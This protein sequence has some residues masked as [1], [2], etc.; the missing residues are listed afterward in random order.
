MKRLLIGIVLIFALFSADYPA[1][2]VQSCGPPKP[3]KPQRRT[4]GE[5]FPPLPLPATPLRRT[6][7][8]RQPR[9]PT[10]FAKVAYGPEFAFVDGKKVYWPDWKTDPGD[11]ETLMRWVNSKLNIHYGSIETSFKKFSY[12]VNEVPVLYLTGHTAPTIGEATAGKLRAFLQ[13]GGFLVADACC[14][15][16]DYREGFEKMMRQVFPDRPL[17]TLPLEHPLFHCFHDCTQVDYLHLEGDRPSYPDTPIVKGIDIGCRTA[18]FYF[19][20]DVSCGWAGHTHP[21]GERYTIKDAR[22]LGANLVT[23]IIANYQLG[24]YLSSAKV[25]YQAGEK[26]RDEFVFGQILHGGDWDPSPSGIA[27]LLEFVDQQSSIS[28]Q[29]KKVAVRPDSP[30]VFNFPFLYIIGHYDFHFNDAAVANLRRF[31]DNGGILFGEACCGRKEFDAAFRR[32]IARVLPGTT[33][34][35]LP[36]S[37]PV[38]NSFW[39]IRT[40]G[41]SRYALETLGNVNRPL[42]EGIKI[43][44]NLAVIYSPLAVANGWERFDHPYSRGYDAASALKLGMNVLVYAMSH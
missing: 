9:P 32:E 21:A 17:R 19:P 25:Y 10:L 34:K 15:S 38:Y 27:N 7:K 26:T 18:V 14:G 33:L 29:Y 36:L 44:G 16:H 24:R 20:R 40:V 41:Y 30:E 31:F 13:D 28:V 4:G 42:F 2:G 22:D 35:R 6:E 3:A 39:N 37:S 23:Y 11:I 12:D 8:K 43:N 1:F 5:S